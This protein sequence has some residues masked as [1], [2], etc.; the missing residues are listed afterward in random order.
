MVVQ[1]Q[2]QN[3]DPFPFAY[4]DTMREEDLVYLL[5]LGIGCE[6][7]ADAHSC[8]LGQPLSVVIFQDV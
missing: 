7:V 4:F 2:L 6:K 3:S 1:D 5:Y 8:Y